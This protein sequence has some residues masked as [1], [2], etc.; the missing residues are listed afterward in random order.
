MQISG[1]PLSDLT[2]QK[3]AS[4]QLPIAHPRPSRAQTGPVERQCKQRSLADIRFVRYRMLYAKPTLSGNG[5]PRVGLND[6][7]I[8]QRLRD[9]GNDAETLHVAKYIFPR[10]FGLH[11]VFTS[12]VDRAETAQPFKDYSLRDKEIAHAADRQRR[13]QRAAIDEHQQSWK[14]HVPKRLRGEAMRLIQSVRRRHARCPYHALLEHHCPRVSSKQ[15]TDQG[16]LV[17]ATSFS[18]VSAYCRAIVHK[19]F[20]QALWGH[21]EAG[22]ANFR[23]LMH[24]TARFVRLRRYETFSLHDV[25]QG[26]NLSCIQ[27]LAPPKIDPVA[28]LGRSDFDKRRELLAEI[29]YYLFDSF[30]IP[31]IRGTFHVTESSF[32]RN[33][34]FYFRHDV[35]RHMTES[36]L[37]LLKANN[38]EPCGTAEVRQHLARR[39]LGISQIRLVPK[40]AGMRP[41]INLR[42][43]VQ[44]LQHGQP[45]L[46]KSINSL[47]TPTFSVLNAEKEARPGMLGSALFS[48]DD[49]FPRLQRFRAHLEKTGRAGRPLYFAKV[50]VQACFD[51]IPQ[52]RVMRIASEIV[53]P[54]GYHISR[55]SRGK[56]VGWEDETAPAFGCKPSWKFV[57][58]AT[59]YDQQ[60][61]FVEHA[62]RDVA[63]GRKR[64]VYIDGATQKPESRK[65]ILE[66]LKEHVENNLI[67]IGRHFYRQKQG[68]PQGSIISSLLCSYVYA[69]L[70]RD[71][72]GFLK[73]GN[74]LLLRLIDDFLVISPDRSVAER[75]MQVM[76]AGVPEFGVQVKVEK[77]RANFDVTVSGQQIMPLPRTVD[78]PY[79]GYSINTATLD[80][81]RD[82]VRRR[83]ANLA[84]SVTV[85]LSNVPGQ[86]FYRKTLNALKLQMHA[87]LLSTNYNSLQTVLGNIYHSFIEVAQKCS[88]YMRSLQGSKRPR[89]RLLISRLSVHKRQARRR[90]WRSPKSFELCSVRGCSPTPLA[91]HTADSL[92]PR[93]VGRYDQACLSTHAAPQ[94]HR[95][96]HDAIQVFR[97]CIS[98]PLVSRNTV[99]E[100]CTCEVMTEEISR[101]P[102][103]LRLGRSQPPALSISDR[104]QLNCMR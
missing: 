44:R 10:Q 59:P 87:M 62:V 58:K 71:V 77:S 90:G 23:S 61:S 66:I 67:R 39:S 52:G 93:N 26:F 91:D 53:Q 31:L 102:A 37:G 21:G 29:L 78:F 13:K 92:T 97:E 30:L 50:D 22:R 27:W 88:C 38:L 94:A 84:D 51:T 28:K 40:E 64:T 99:P 83:R 12:S 43:R 7:H 76:H 8:L 63:H 46:G 49:L 11:N 100:K 32:N 56:L 48:V 54:Q 72:L 68:I 25:V 9:V 74:T 18:A 34:L 95:H 36:A 69:E 1:I 85:E 98:S 41:I 45:V 80:V 65:A 42:R 82:H 4:W 24:L 101:L 14:H 60:Y 33:Q 17:Q 2:A 104:L 55:Y 47:L 19:V 6:I 79:C 15:S 73:D 35:W 89:C 75:F 70:E 103:C 86:T 20:P 96:R 5:N 3:Q 16:S 81:T 57:T